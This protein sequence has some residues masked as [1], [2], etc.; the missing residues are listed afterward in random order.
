[1]LVLAASSVTVMPTPSFGLGTVVPGMT[2]IWR[3]VAL[4]CG[5]RRPSISCPMSR[6][7]APVWA[8]LPRIVD[9]ACGSVSVF[10][11]RSGQTAVGETA[12]GET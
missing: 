5:L 1:M 10:G 3:R 7:L 8:V 9:P 11:A 4:V 2:T 12:V 6:R